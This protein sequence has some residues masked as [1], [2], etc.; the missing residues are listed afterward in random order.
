MRASEIGADVL[1]KGTKV[2]G[3]FSE[4]PN[5]NDK[6]TFYE[7]LCYMEVVQQELGFMDLTAITMCKDNKLPII[8][9]NMRK[10]GNLKKIVMGEPV[11]TI[12]S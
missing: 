8:V 5:K 2:E 11:G 4:D 12:I 9:F 3:V 10:S 7:K 1:I 6:A